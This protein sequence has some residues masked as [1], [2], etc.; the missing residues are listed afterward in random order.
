MNAGGISGG[1]A[2]RAALAAAAAIALGGCTGD[3]QQTASLLQRAAQPRPAPARA[4]QE[5]EPLKPQ[6]TPFAVAPAPPPT[7][8]VLPPPSTPVPEAPHIAAGRPPSL[9]PDVTFVIRLAS[10]DMTHVDGRPGMSQVVEAA[11]SYPESQIYLTAYVTE[12]DTRARH[13]DPG[14]LADELVISMAKFLAD[15]GI[16]PKRISGKGAGVDKTVGRAIVVSLDVNAGTAA[17]N[18]PPSSRYRAPLHPI[19]LSPR[20]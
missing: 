2:S 20:S 19:A 17:G 11:Q 15:R 16:D 4:S 12:D 5:R 8:P 1:R 14:N 18:G 13:T 10:L 9:K 3:L 7:V 6:P